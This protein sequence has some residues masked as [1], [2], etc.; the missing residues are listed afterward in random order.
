MAFLRSPQLPTIKS[1]GHNYRTANMSLFTRSLLYLYLAAFGSLSIWMLSKG[2][3]K[4]AAF[5]VLLAAIVSPALIEVWFPGKY[6]LRKPQDGSV[7]TLVG[8][9]RQFRKDQPGWDGTAILAVLVVLLTAGLGQSLL[10][11]FR[12]I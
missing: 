4:L 5:A 9:L 11:L 10:A 8:R 12:F 6:V 2:E 7:D 1:N 3:Y